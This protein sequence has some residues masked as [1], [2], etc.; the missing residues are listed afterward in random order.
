MLIVGVLLKVTCF[1]FCIIV[2][3]EGLLK[4]VIHAKKHKYCL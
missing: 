4:D 2:Y 3:I 1:S